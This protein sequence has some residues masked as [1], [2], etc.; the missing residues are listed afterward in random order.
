LP[1]ARLKRQLGRPGADTPLETA[2]ALLP[3]A[4]IAFS[5]FLILTATFARSFVAA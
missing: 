1:A 4:M 3:W 2:A 5:V